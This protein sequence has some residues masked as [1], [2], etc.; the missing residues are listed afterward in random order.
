MLRL[1]IF[2]HE[3]S[4]SDS[5]G[6]VLINEVTLHR[7]EPN[8]M[9]FLILVIPVI[10]AVSNNVFKAN[11]AHITSKTRD[12][13]QSV[14]GQVHDTELSVGY[15]DDKPARQLPANLFMEEEMKGWGIL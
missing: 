9:V 7:G 1:E 6:G 2:P 12:N 13:H 10:F 11:L 15:V 4:V 14:D 5:P 8:I 3:I